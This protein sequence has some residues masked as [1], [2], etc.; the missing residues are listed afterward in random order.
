MARSEEEPI[1][2]LKVAIIF[3]LF[4][5]SRIFRIHML[6]FLYIVLMDHLGILESSYVTPSPLVLSQM[7]LI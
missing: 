4:T 2:G 1:M 5:M 7:R 3:M 6:D